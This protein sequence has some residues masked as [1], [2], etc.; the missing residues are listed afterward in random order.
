MVT[1]SHTPKGNF[2]SKR[3]NKN[4]YKGKGGRKYGKPDRFGTLRLAPSLANRTAAD[5]WFTRRD[6]E[7]LRSSCMA[8][9]RHDEF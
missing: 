5:D 1:G 4:F 3:G 6:L 8:H 9:A 2:S 7:A